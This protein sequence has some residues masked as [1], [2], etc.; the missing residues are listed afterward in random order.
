MGRGVEPSFISVLSLFPLEEEEGME[1]PVVV[2]GRGTNPR[3]MVRWR[4]SLEGS[5]ELWLPLLSCTAERRL[6]DLSRRDHECE[7]ALAVLD[8]CLVATAEYFW[9]ADP[10]D[11]GSERY[12]VEIP[13]V[14]RLLS[15]GLASWCEQYDVPLLGKVPGGEKKVG[16]TP[17]R[18]VDDR[19]DVLG[20]VHD[21]ILGADHLEE[22]PAAVVQRLREESPVEMSST[23]QWCLVYGSRVGATEALLHMLEEQWSERDRSLVALNAALLALERVYFSLRRT[24][25]ADFHVGRIL[26]LVQRVLVR[27]GRACL[28][29]C[30]LGSDHAWST[31]R[32]MQ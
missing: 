28:V 26:S 6:L 22:R 5:G 25:R 3:C 7:Q 21:A 14:Q 23:C 29:L 1:I 31:R 10:E 17:V 13:E 11:E 27:E 19:L 12:E 15:L 18:S 24:G 8:R 20:A 16:E 4:R 30:R 32:V 2:A 9:G